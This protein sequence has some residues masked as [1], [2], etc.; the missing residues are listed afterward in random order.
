M[1]GADPQ[2]PLCSQPCKSGG[3][4][5]GSWFICDTCG[6]FNLA[7]EAGGAINGLTV[8]Q[9]SWLSHFTRTKWNLRRAWRETVR[10]DT[11]K[12]TPAMIDSK[13]VERVRNG[14]LA[15][16]RAQQAANAIKYIGD[17]ALEEGG[18]ITLRYGSPRFA[19]VIGAPNSDSAR[20]LM[21]ELA[22]AD[23]IKWNEP[24]Y[25]QG[26]EEHYAN[27]DLTLVGWEQYEEMKHG[28]HDGGYGFFAWQFGSP[29]TEPVFEH[30]LKPAFEE[31]G[32]P[33]RDMKDLSQPGLIDNIMQDRIRNAS[34][35]I[36]D[37]TDC[38]PGAYWEGGFAQALEKPVVYICHQE[39]FNDPATKPHFD[40]N[41]YTIVFWG[42][43]KSNEEFVEELIATLRRHPGELD[44]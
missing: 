5:W 18:T 34:F 32:Y 4:D 27:A 16:T 35:V 36:V 23:T 28:S 29:I 14:D 17:R 1:S 43:D 11:P 7:L 25:F 15:V 26:G 40:A 21:G 44:L 22:A 6:R 38:N 39:A 2:C 3:V 12:P 10:D 33:L 13:L 42:D 20:E 19:A 8:T 9:R 41:H 30:V 31:Q 37:L 24:E